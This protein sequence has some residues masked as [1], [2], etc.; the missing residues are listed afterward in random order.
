[1]SKQSW[2]EA[3]VLA[4]PVSGPTTID[5]SSD[6]ARNATTPPTPWRQPRQSTH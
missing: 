5:L 3:G 4:S 6:W 2:P 1:V